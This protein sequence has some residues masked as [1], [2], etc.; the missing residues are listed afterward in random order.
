MKKIISIEKS[1]VNNKEKKTVLSD[2]SINILDNSV[3]A[4]LGPNGSGKTTLLKIIC[5]LIYPDKGEILGLN[6]N[7]NR[8]DYREI[9]VVLEGARNL[10]WRLKVKD[11]FR[12]FGILKGLSTKEIK[13]NTDYYVDKFKLNEV[14]D[15]PVYSLSLGQKQ[16]VSLICALITNPTLILL[17]EPSNGLDIYNIEI[18][19]TII[20]EE[21]NRNNLSFL[22]TS[23]DISF[24]KY[25]FDFGYIIKNG[26]ILDSFDKNILFKTNFEDYYKYKLEEV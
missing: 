24:I 19:E 13:Q 6:F 8:L 2:V 25:I 20:M 26:K 14:I 23:H 4:L 15:R 22:V 1:F 9:S 17:D 12:Y 7:S 10:P 16:V 3:V 5:G 18:L 11:N 21:K